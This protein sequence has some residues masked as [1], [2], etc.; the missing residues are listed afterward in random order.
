MKNAVILYLFKRERY[1]GFSGML[2]LKIAYETAEA[3]QVDRMVP[4]PLL[5]V[6]AA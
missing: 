5:V 2:Q 3:V 1:V 4:I 6:K